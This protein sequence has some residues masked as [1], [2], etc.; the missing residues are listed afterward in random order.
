MPP[1]RYESP[2]ERVI[3]AIV[4][5]VIG[6]S[7]ILWEELSPPIEPQLLIIYVA[8]LGFSGVSILRDAIHR[9]TSN[10]PDPPEDRHDDTR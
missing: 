1:I 7:G 2:V 4:F 6:I 9:L 5:P 8:M 3:R 10:P